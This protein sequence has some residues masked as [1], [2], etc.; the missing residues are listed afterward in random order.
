MV[1]QVDTLVVGAGLVGSSV[2]MH[3]AEMGMSGIRVIDFDLEGSFSSS[4]LNA[5]GVRATW[6]EPINVLMAKKTIEYFATVAD[7]VGYRACGYL[8][9]HT[10]GRI[11]AAQA[12]AQKQNSLGWPVEVLSVPEIQKR[13]PFL[14]K[15]EGIAGAIFSE[16]DGLINPNL[17]KNHYRAR[18][19]ALGVVYEDRTLLREVT[20]TGGVKG[21]VDQKKDGH[22]V[23]AKAERFE[24]VMSY[25]TKR[26][27]LT[28]SLS[29]A[30]RTRVEYHAKNI[31]NCA[32]PWASQVA[33][34]MGYP[35]PSFPLRRQVSIFDCREID[36][37]PYGM[38]VDTSGVYF[39]PEATNGLAGMATQES[40]GFNYTYEGESF[41]QEHIWPAL[42]ER[43]TGFEKLKH[44][45]GWAGLYEVS[46]DECAIIGPVKKGEA[47]RSGAVYEAH[48]FSGHGVMH[49]Y[50]AGLA[51]AEKIIHGQYQSLDLARLSAERFDQGQT[52]SEN[53]VI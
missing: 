19:K 11:R 25:E 33:E 27:V 34:M 30:G 41:F 44:L 5:G 13:L 47:G 29:H 7:D 51:L 28:E 38:I 6:V 37:T 12:A 1:Q 9:M 50:A 24:S 42:Y 3:L 23:H 49:S 21:A 10:E 4:E 40:R 52:L 35:C 14:D 26:D 36:L 32:G 18:G 45:T 48:S 53:L 8:W 17:L 2:A 16:R 15:T 20:F 46:P 43:S 39:H 22:K 31:I